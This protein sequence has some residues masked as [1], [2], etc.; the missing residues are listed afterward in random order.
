VSVFDGQADLL[1]TLIASSATFQTL[2][3]TATVAAA[4]AKI[5]IHEAFD[6]T[7]G[8]DA[9]ITYPRAIVADGGIVERELVGTANRKG[10]GS[11]FLSFEFESPADKTTILLQRTWFVGQVSTIMREAEV[12]SDSRATP[13]GYTS[14][15]ILIRRYRRTFGPQVVLQCDRDQTTN[16]SGRNLWAMEFEIEY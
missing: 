10:T 13:S 16:D 3:G 6:D 15:H 5:G 8:S 14:T 2:T 11:L 7:I 9:A 12:I 4:K 1:A